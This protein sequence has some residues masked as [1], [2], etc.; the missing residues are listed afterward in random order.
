[1]ITY[2]GAVSWSVTFD[3]KLTGERGN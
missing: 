3:V 2:E 1:V